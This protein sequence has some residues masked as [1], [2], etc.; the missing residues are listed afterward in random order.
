MMLL[1]IVL[2]AVVAILICAIRAVRGP[3]APD[4]ILAFDAIT[5]LL[6]ATLVILGVHYRI[7]MLLDIALVYALLAFLGTLAIAKYLEGRSVES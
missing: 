4:R 2:I 3:T 5:G 7:S 1:W 6:T